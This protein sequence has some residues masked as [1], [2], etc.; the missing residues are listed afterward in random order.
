[1][2]DK[3]MTAE[4]TYGARA[5]NGT[6]NWGKSANGVAQIGLSFEITSEGPYKGRRLPWYGS[7]AQGDASRIAIEALEAAGANLDE[8]VAGESS[9][10]GLGGN[11]CSIVVKH[12]T[13]K[14]YVDGLLVDKLD[15]D[16]GEPIVAPTVAFV[17]R[18]GATFKTK[19]DA[20]EAS[21][22]TS[23]IGALVA[24]RKGGKVPVGQDGKPLF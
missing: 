21:N 18:G 19:L 24:A 16:T 9:I 10:P 20:D 12:K 23:A 8:I 11:E 3:K 6:V 15:E 1:M 2:S 14:T 7:F 13:L 22:L 17:N 4:G 5:V